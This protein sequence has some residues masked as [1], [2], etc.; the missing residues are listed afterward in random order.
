MKPTHYVR[1]SK[2]TVATLAVGMFAVPAC[3]QD[4]D[5]MGGHWATFSEQANSYQSSVDSHAA[6][7]A[8]AP[9]FSRIA[10]LETEHVT[11]T[12]PNMNAMRHEFGD[13]MSC[14]G[15][16]GEQVVSRQVLADFDR[17]EQESDGHMGAMKEATDMDTVQAEETRHY[18]QMTEIFGD[19]RTHA[20]DMME[21]NSNYNCSHHLR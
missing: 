15:P 12:Q 3:A 17:L 18:G 7:V 13:M 20:E 8:S 9:D 21:G 1:T 11:L 6:A 4:M 19:M 16:S 14:T 10:E 2:V 5:T